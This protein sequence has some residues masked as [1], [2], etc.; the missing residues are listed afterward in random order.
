MTTLPDR[1][2]ADLR[3]A[4]VDH[5]AVVPDGPG[6]YHVYFGHRA[7]TVYCDGDAYLVR[8]TGWDDGLDGRW[9]TLVAFVDAA[10]GRR[11]GS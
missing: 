2:A 8:A 1:L 6:R 3:E 10:L 9:P 5:D 4:G 11:R 7:V